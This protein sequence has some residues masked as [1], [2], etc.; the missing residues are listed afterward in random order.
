M[1]AKNQNKNNATADSE[2]SLLIITP[3]MTLLFL[4]TLFL[5]GRMVWSHIYH[6]QNRLGANSMVFDKAGNSLLPN[7]NFTPGV[8]NPKVTQ[9]NIQ[10]TICLAGWTATIRPPS[11]YTTDLKN[12]QIEQYGYKDKTMA[13][14]EED[15]LIS[16][17]LGGDPTDPKNLWPENYNTNPGARQKDQ[18]EDY[19]H[20][21]VCSGE[22]TLSKAQHIISTDWVSA[23]N[24][25]K[26]K[27]TNLG[28]IT[29]IDEDDQ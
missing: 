7:S 29:N 4:L 14:Y 9:A 19:L 21:K 15:H 5:F 18:V 12:K 28:S 16:L 20:R 17:E 13:D 26:T 6:A 2:V 22:M 8:V 27:N 11:S 23:Y 25:I 3:I 24:L 1:T 10:T